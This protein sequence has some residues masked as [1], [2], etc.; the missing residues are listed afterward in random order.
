MSGL[1]GELDC[2]TLLLSDSDQAVL[3]Y[4]AE[5]GALEATALDLLRVT[6]VQH[7]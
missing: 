5:P 7:F 1:Q 2:D 3:V 4:S 6:G